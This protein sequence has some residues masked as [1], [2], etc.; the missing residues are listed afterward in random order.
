MGRNVHWTLE[1]S[2]VLG[3]GQGFQGRD[4]KNQVGQSL[5]LLQHK[6][7]IILEFRNGVTS[8]H[9]STWGTKKFLL[10]S[11]FS[12]GQLIT[13]SNVENPEMTILTKL[14]QASMTLISSTQH[15]IYMYCVQWQSV[16]EECFFQYQKILT[17]YLEFFYSLFS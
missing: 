13:Q 16:R 2:H 8:E 7:S 15:L 11:Y 6:E 10:R 9:D 4:L 3:A 1:D 17:E 12:G 14:M 5:C